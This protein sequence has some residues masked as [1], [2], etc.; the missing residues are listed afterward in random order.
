MDSHPRNKGGVNPSL[1]QLLHRM[2]RFVPSVKRPD[3]MDAGGIGRPDAEKHSFLSVLNA[4]M[5][6]Q[7]LVNV[8][9]RPL[10]KQVLVCLRNKNF[11]FC[12]FFFHCSKPPI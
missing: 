5:G 1:S 11:P 6:S 2:G 10:G 3:H 12:P 9:V 7:L 8:I 4:G